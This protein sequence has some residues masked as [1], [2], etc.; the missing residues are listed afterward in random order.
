MEWEVLSTS[1]PDGRFSL[2]LSL[3]LSHCIVAKV[4]NTSLS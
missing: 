1:R 3:S 4:K 2:S